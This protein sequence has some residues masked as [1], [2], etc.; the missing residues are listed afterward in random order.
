[1]VAMS[2]PPSIK[3]KAPSSGRPN[4]TTRV[5]KDA[6]LLLGENVGRDATSRPPQ[7]IDAPEYRVAISGNRTLPSVALRRM[8]RRHRGRGGEDGSV[9]AFNLDDSYGPDGTMPL[10]QHA[11]KGLVEDAARFV[12]ELAPLAAG[13]IGVPS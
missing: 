7:M 9:T 5:L 11:V 2:L 12:P 13:I 1:M 4:K 8:G 6:I 3:R 10:D